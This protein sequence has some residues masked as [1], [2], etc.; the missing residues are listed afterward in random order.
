MKL[1]GDLLNQLGHGG[2]TNALVGLLN[3]N[4]QLAEAATALLGDDSS[5]GPAGGLDEVLGAL[6]KSGLGDAVGSWLSNGPNQA[7][8]G[9]QLTKALGADTLAQFANRAG[10]DSAAAPDALSSLLPQLVD[11]LSPQGTLPAGGD[12]AG[13]LGGL[14]RR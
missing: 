14:L 13:L 8:S 6:R 12:L 9:T 11:Q 2:G 3:N 10:I 5:V 4:P 1:L 7:V